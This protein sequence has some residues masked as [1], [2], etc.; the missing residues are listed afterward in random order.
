MDAVRDEEKVKAVLHGKGNHG[1]VMMRVAAAR[2]RSGCPPGR[3]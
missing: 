2:V 3:P 1:M